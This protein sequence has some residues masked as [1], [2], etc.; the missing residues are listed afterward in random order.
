MI[1][2]MLLGNYSGPCIPW[3]ILTQ[4]ILTS[5]TEA[6]LSTIARYLGPFGKKSLKLYYDRVLGHLML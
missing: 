5:T 1:N 6:L 2:I 4:G 3:G